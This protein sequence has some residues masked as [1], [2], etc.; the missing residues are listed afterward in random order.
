MRYT[1]TIGERMERFSR[2]FASQTSCADFRSVVIQI[3]GKILYRGTL[4]GG[5]CR[6][7]AFES[8]VDSGREREKKKEKSK[9]RGRERN[10][11]SKRAIQWL[12]KVFGRSKLFFVWII[13]N[14][15]SHQR[16]NE[17]R[18]SSLHRWNFK[19]TKMCVRMLQDIRWKY[20][21][22]EDYQSIWTDSCS[23]DCL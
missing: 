13:K 7:I 20:T 18:L 5:T 19:P 2:W 16:R 8:T 14:I 9:S 15:F 4:E 3:L 21:F 17:A 10:A 1:F 11:D 12:A 22:R 6:V 23:L